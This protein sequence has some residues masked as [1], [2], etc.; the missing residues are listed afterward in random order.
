MLPLLTESIP[1][2]R[3]VCLPITGRVHGASCPVPCP[4]TCDS[5]AVW[6][7]S[8]RSLV[9]EISCASYECTSFLPFP[10]QE[11]SNLLAN[12]KSSIEFFHE[13]SHS[14]ALTPRCSHLVGLP[15]VIAGPISVGC[16]QESLDAAS[17]NVYNMHMTEV[18]LDRLCAATGR[19]PRWGH[20]CGVEHATAGICAVDPGSIGD[21][22]QWD[23]LCTAGTVHA[24]HTPHCARAL[25]DA[26]VPEYL[27]GTYASP[28]AD[29]VP[30]PGVLSGVACA[31]PGCLR[32]PADC[33]C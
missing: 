24:W 11:Y 33:N 30:A 5:F 18:W 15:S 8:A 19:V 2:A 26:R 32:T 21:P 9:P 16:F 10:I 29:C 31:V 22:G 1:Y 13:I 20:T 23:G 14:T 27:P 17:H 28:G 3:T 12:V 6:S 7:R 4:I 25:G